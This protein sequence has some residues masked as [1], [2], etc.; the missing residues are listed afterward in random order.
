[1]RQTV[2]EM[3]TNMFKT[4]FEL[5][6]IYAYVH[7]ETLCLAYWFKHLFWI[8]TNSFSSGNLEK[9]IEQTI[10]RI[11][12][13]V[14]QK[15]TVCSGYWRFRLL[16][17]IAWFIAYLHIFFS[18]L[19]KSI[20]GVEF[21]FCQPVINSQR[22]VFLMPFSS[23]E[24]K[25]KHHFTFKQQVLHKQVGSNEFLPPFHAIDFVQFRLIMLFYSS[26]QAYMLSLHSKRALLFFSRH[27]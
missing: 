1:M 4:D 24:F 10:P 3:F 14:F 21:N 8:L 15:L 23:I 18:N 27:V 6:F 26:E 5:T 19:N 7:I 12:W 25:S 17:R 9:K 2:G 11:R 16:V 13:K 22:K 20:L